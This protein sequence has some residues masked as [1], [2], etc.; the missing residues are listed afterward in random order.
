MV[1]ADPWK[2]VCRAFQSSIGLYSARLWASGVLV[3]TICLA[4]QPRPLFSSARSASILGSFGPE[5]PFPLYCFAGDKLPKPYRKEMQTV[6][7]GALG[8][9]LLLS[10]PPSKSLGFPYTLAPLRNPPRFPIHL[11]TRS[12]CILV[13]CC[14]GP[15]PQTV[16]RLAPPQQPLSYG[17]L[18]Q[19]LI[20]QGRRTLY[21]ALLD[22]YT[23]KFISALPARPV[24]CP[25]PAAGQRHPQAD[26][27]PGPV[28]SHPGGCERG[29][30]GDLE[31]WPHPSPRAQ[32]P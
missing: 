14:A 6:Q 4:G 27:P 20:Q 19:F 26:S 16:N 28:H 7:H 22:S 5:Y 11:G 18:G 15:V 21:P 24:T 2:E 17:V 30:G 9:R 25:R 12:Y 31:A 8:W 32:P 29:S 10:M 3:F 1:A 23:H 13:I